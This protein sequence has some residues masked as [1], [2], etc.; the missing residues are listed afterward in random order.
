MKT[1][2]WIAMLISCSSKTTELPA[3]GSAVAAG[4]PAMKPDEC[5]KKLDCDKLFPP[6]VRGTLLAGM[7]ITADAERIEC[8]VDDPKRASGALDVRIMPGPVAVNVPADWAAIAK[9]SGVTPLEGVGRYASVIGPGTINN[10]FMLPSKLDCTVRVTWEK[11]LA[12]GT[13]LAR[14]VD[15]NIVAAAGR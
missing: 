6:S 1:L 3:A 8:S 9:K 5:P 13:E 2:L 15:A 4:A 11:D 10:I 14:V 7:K 12:K